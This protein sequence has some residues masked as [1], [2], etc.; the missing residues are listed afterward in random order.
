MADLFRKLN[1]LIKAGL[2]DLLP[3]TSTVDTSSRPAMQA[4]LGRDAALLRDRVNRAL[5]QEAAL[6]A[7]VQQL[8]REI[9]DHDRAADGAVQQGNDDLARKHV[10]QM[11]QTQRFLAIADADLREHQRVTA[12]LIQNVNRLEAALADHRAQQKEQAVAD[13]DAAENIAERLL[14]ET[15]ETLNRMNATISATLGRHT[16]TAQSASPEAA[17]SSPASPA[18]QP[19]ETTAPSPAQASPRGVDDDLERRRKRLS[20]PDS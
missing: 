13:A 16:S 9:E 5:D 7:H 17:S 2:N 12:E 4:Q 14:R 15:R 19:Q 10:E 6:Q 8:L 3:K 20:K 11:Q 18:A 1:T